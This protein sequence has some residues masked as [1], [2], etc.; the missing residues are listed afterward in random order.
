MSRTEGTKVPVQNVTQ[1]ATM[2]EWPLPPTS[3]HSERQTQSLESSSGLKAQ[4]VPKAQP[5]H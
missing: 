1:S 3:T 4:H 5:G 2:E